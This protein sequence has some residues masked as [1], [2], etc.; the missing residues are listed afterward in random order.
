MSKTA[1]RL[2][3]ENENEEGSFFEKLFGFRSFKENDRSQ[4]LTDGDFLDTTAGANQITGNEEKFFLDSVIGTSK[5][6][7]QS[8]V[9]TDT[10]LVAGTNKELAFTETLFGRAEDE[11]SSEMANLISPHTHES[12]YVRFL[13][14]KIVPKYETTL[15]E[16]VK[17]QRYDDFDVTERRIQELN[18]AVVLVPIF[19]LLT[20]LAL[21]ITGLILV[22]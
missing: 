21:Y 3:P 20:T 8:E 19:A 2:L 17:E 6:D 14:S 13:F 9:A 5:E 12:G 22:R 4:I 7:V 11:T 15:K 10:G 16:F 18:C 1:L